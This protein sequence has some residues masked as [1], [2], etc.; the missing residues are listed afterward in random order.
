MLRN[1]ILFY[2]LPALT[3]CASPQI[4]CCSYTRYK[5]LSFNINYQRL[6]NF[7]GFFFDVQFRSCWTVCKNRQKRNLNV[8]NYLFILTIHVFAS[9]GN[10]NRLLALYLYFFHCIAMLKSIARKGLTRTGRYQALQTISW[11]HVA[12]FCSV[13][14]QKSKSSSYPHFYYYARHI[15]NNQSINNSFAVASFH[16]R[17]TPRP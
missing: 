10:T 14:V 15:R 16:V 1:N 13:S 4:S 9:Q 7:G 3:P 8:N 2:H 11:Y 17:R 6:L 5:D 12:T